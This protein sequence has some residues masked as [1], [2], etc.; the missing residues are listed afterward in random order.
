MCKNHVFAY[1]TVIGLL[2]SVDVMGQADV[3]GWKEE[4]HIYA[5]VY[6]AALRG[7][8]LGNTTL[9][10][11][12]HQ[13]PTILALVFTRCTGICSPFLM[14]LKEKLE[15]ERDNKKFNIVVISFDP[16]DTKK[17]MYLYAK[18]FGLDDDK[19]W[20]FAVTDSIQHLSQS[21]GFDPV[22]DSTRQQY[23]HEAI[24][25]GINTEGYITK[26]LLGLRSEHELA[27]LIGSINNIF[28]PSYRIPNKNLLFSCFNYNA[29]TGK[30]MP[31]LGLVFIAL[32]AIIT[33]L[34]LLS[35]SYFVRSSRM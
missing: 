35:I 24:L 4:G 29:K 8:K 33:L 21:I 34:I 20:V 1:L 17:D 16:R 5:K 27:L 13:N 6:D 32:P 11:I 22:W 19:R 14:Q 15:S 28:S 26:K 30:N 2:C 18:N 10:Q 3:S 31:G 9:Y 7:N 12:V 25:V 23:D